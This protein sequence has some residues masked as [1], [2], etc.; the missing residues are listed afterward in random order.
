M[1]ILR[2]VT[3]C[4]SCVRRSLVMHSSAL[5]DWE[6]TVAMAALPTSPWNTAMKTT[7]STVLI[8]EEKIR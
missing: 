8:T 3:R 5:T 7:S 4:S 2:S 1:R 6:I